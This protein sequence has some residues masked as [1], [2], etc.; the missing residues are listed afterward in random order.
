M[1]IFGANVFAVRFPFA[2]ISSITS[3][4]VYLS[5]K[6][7]SN[8]KPLAILSS[9]YFI[10]MMPALVLG[11]L[12]LAENLIALLFMVNVY[13]TLR[14]KSSGSDGQKWWFLLGGL[15]A[16]AGTLVKFD[17]IIIIV[18]F[19]VFA[20]KE[21]L[22]RRASPYVGLCLVLGIFLPLGAVQ[23]V[24]RS[25]STLL[26]SRLFPFIAEVGNQLILISFFFVN[27]LPSGIA[28]FWK[29]V[30]FQP[31]FWYIFLYFALVPIILY[32]YKQYSDV[33]LAIGVFVAFFATF[34]GAFGS[35]WL[36]MIQPLLA[37]CFGPS[38]KRLIN[39]PFFVSLVFYGLMFAPLATSVGEY[40]ITPA[41]VGNLRILNS[42]LFVWNLCVALPLVAILFLTV[43]NYDADSKWRP[44]VNGALLAAF[45]GTLLVGTFLVPDLYPFYVT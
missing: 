6:A 36:I 23:F 37:I 40:L 5:T 7:V 44:W 17:G 42:S 10:I 24:T 30:V 16:A 18:Y 8:S 3:V 2:V 41:Q 15:S 34:S 11:R 31:E 21:K 32:S 38:L 26:M 13:S 25:A 35:Y 43:R 20:L 33:L 29:G 4:F 1:H 22:L 39:M 45:F 27:T 14:I 9:L 28:V 12:A 19:V